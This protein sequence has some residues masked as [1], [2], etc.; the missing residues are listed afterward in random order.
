ME[1]I[2]PTGHWRAVSAEGQENWLRCGFGEGEIQPRVL[3]L[4]QRCSH[5]C[6]QYEGLKG[7]VMRDQ[8]EDPRELIEDINLP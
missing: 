2:I 5:E 6:P 7:D 3:A 4:G 8:H 1:W